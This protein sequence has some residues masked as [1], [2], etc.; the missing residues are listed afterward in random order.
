MTEF[1]IRYL[2]GLVISEA[3][4]TETAG[5]IALASLCA[6]VTFSHFLRLNDCGWKNTTA[7]MSTPLAGFGLTSC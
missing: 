3:L 5:S 1:E 4:L 7:P 6:R 2:T